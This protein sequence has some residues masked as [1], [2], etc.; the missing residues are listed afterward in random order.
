MG[1][2]ETINHMK[3]LLAE[4]S[5]DLEKSVNGNKTASQRVRVHTIELEKTAKLYRKESVAA[6]RKGSG[7]AK[8]SVAKKTAA[9]KTTA[10]AAKKKK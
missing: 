7:R 10:K 2:K 1:L 4:I 3:R 8:A 5:V 6:E 9:K